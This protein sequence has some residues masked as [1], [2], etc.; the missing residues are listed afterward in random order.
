M[1][2]TSLTESESDPEDHNVDPEYF[3]EKFRRALRDSVLKRFGTDQDS[4]QPA[5]VRGR[6]IVTSNVVNDKYYILATLL[7]PKLKTIPFEGNLQ[8][9]AAVH[10]NYFICFEQ[11]RLLNFYYIL[12]K[13]L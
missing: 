6:K 8:Q 10:L 1:D 9:T 5:A 2:I 7:D 11:S 13:V 12:Q 3:L 4:G